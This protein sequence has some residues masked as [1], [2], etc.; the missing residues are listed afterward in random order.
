MK[1]TPIY[2]IRT[3]TTDGISKNTFYVNTYLV[4][5]I[6]IHSFININSSR[7]ICVNIT[8]YYIH[9]FTRRWY[10]TSILQHIS[11]NTHCNNDQKNFDGKISSY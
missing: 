7:Y 11:P 2:G 5:H 9:L 3:M 8:S 4:L 1:L 10:Y 6:Y